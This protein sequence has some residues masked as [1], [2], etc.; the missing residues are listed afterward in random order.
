[1]GFR[2]LN[3]AVDCNSNEEQVEAQKILDE[4]SNVLRLKAD[5]L[6]L[7]APMIR[8]NQSMLIGIFRKVT[9]NPGLLKVFGI[10]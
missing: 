7:N 1:M 8:K 10:K 4:I 5:E 9:S 2:R 3:I 6:I